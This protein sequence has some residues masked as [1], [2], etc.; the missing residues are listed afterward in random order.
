AVNVDSEAAFNLTVDNAL[1]GLSGKSYAIPSKRIAQI[2][3]K[4]PAMLGY[5]R[6]VGNSLN[7]F[8]YEAF[9]DELADKGGWWKPRRK[10]WT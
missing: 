8:F 4:G 5:W 10:G 6:S 1:E 2:Y 3:V 9:L 7:D